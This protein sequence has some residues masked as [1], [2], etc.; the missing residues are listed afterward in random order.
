MI[1]TLS[2][3]ELALGAHVGMQ[4]QIESLSRGL[5][6]QHGAR[7][8]MGWQLHIEGAIGELVVAKHLGIFWD[9]SVNTFKLPD[10]GRQVQVRTRSKDHYDLIVRT[11]D[12]D[13][14]LFVL[15]TGVAPTYCVRGCIWGRHAKQLHFWACHGGREGAWFVPQSHLAPLLP[16]TGDDGRSDARRSTLVHG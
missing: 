12:Q 4:R 3:Y 11:N 8:E 15:V 14:D 5:R 16:R 2:P 6:D 7:A 13:D 1:Y 9:G 10:L